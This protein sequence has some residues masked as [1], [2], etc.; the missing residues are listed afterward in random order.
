MKLLIEHNATDEDT[1]F[2]GFV[3]GEPWKRLEVF[4]PDGRLVM[5]TYAN[6]RLRSLGLTELFF[7]TNEPPNAEVPIPDV[8]KKLPAGRYEFRGKTID[9]L[10]ERGV[11]VLSH[12]IP[13]GAEIVAPA[14]D[15]EIRAD[16]DL[17]VRW[18]PVTTALDGETRVTITH[19]QLII[20]RLDQTP[21]AGFGSETFSIHV[22][23]TITKIRVPHEFLQPN[24]RYGL[25][26][27][28]IEKNGN[29]T[30]TSSELATL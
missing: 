2:Q 6:G 14:E 18:R 5:S 19:Y 29:Q 27:L 24:T 3:D 23:S 25:E 22:P 26:V 4:G 9:G 10:T 28:A 8:L 20:E 1:G 12:T 17:I 7:E 13:A 30:I 15:A 11:A 21:G 16:R